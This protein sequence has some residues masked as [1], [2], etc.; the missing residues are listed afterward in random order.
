MTYEGDFASAL[1]RLTHRSGSVITIAASTEKSIALKSFTGRLPTRFMRYKV[2]RRSTMKVSTNLTRDKGGIFMYNPTYFCITHDLRRIGISLTCDRGGIG[3]LKMDNKITCNTL[4]TAR[5]DLRS[6]TMLEAFPKVGVILP[7]S[8]HRAHGLIGLLMSCPRPMCIHMK[9]TT[10]PSICRGSS[11]RFI[12]KGTGALLS[13]ASLAVVTTKRAI[14]RTCRTNLVLHR[15]N[16]RTHILSVSSVGPISIRTV[17]GTTRRAKQVVAMR[18]RD[19]FN[20]LKTV[21][22]RALSRGPIPMH[23]VNV[24]SRGIIRKG[25]RRVFTR[26]KLSG[27][28]VYGATLRFIGGWACPF[29]VW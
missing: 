4:K 19:Q 17:E 20:N 22:I 28:N 2:T 11:F 27:R 25:S 7:Y 21:M 18:R 8:T 12:L 15:G 3:V 13:N 6:V 10:I 14:C 9:E 16:V 1:L 5:R 23:V 24:P 26:C 29:W